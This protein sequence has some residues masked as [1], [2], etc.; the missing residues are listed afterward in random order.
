MTIDELRAMLALRGT[1]NAADADAL[2]DALEWALKQI[3]APK[4]RFGDGSIAPY[5]RAG[6][7]FYWIRWRDA[8]GEVQ[9]ESTKTAD[10]KKAQAVLLRRLKEVGAGKVSTSAQ[11][12]VL[13]TE[14][15]DALLEARAKSADYPSL[16]GRVAKV[17]EYF[18]GARAHSV[19]TQ[20]VRAFARWLAKHFDLAQPTVNRHL[21]ALSS[22]YTHAIKEERISLRPQIR[23]AMGDE[24]PAKQGYFSKAEF[25]AFRD[26]LPEHYRD[27]FTF[28]FHTGRRFGQVGLIEIR[29]VHLEQG[30]IECRSETVK[31]R[32]VDMIPLVGEVAEVVRRAWENRRL[33][34]P[35]L[36]QHD[37]MPLVYAT[38]RGKSRSKP[39]RKAWDAA[40]E[41]TKIRLTPHD[42]RRSYA[43]NLDAA[44][45]RGKDAMLLSGWK[46]LGMIDR[47]NVR[48]FNDL[49]ERA[50]QLGDWLDAQPDE[51]AKVLTLSGGG[52]R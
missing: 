6:S 47:Y 38:E 46:T 40:Q 49:Q 45:I 32:T 2:Y 25:K 31:N 10:V 17:K 5:R 28:L 9:R 11:E 30:Y 33:D 51:P 19:T 52:K 26:A 12:R 3:P 50:K 14:L 27:V 15:A 20:D 43:R 18:A 42:L 1:A 8:R 21:A 29:D 35:Y 24:S 36:F 34:C 16:V 37:G 4:P 22:I 13:V 48:R 44:G 7:P 39:F 23:M 41:A